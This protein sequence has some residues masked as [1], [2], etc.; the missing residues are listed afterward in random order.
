MSTTP[1]LLKLLTLATRAVEAELN[2]ELS[3]RLAAELRPAH[4][5]VFRY[6]DP[7]GSRVGELAAAAGMTQQSMGELV[8]RLERAGLVR[9][10]VDPQDRRAR[11]VVCTEAGLVALELAGERIAR[12]EDRIRAD[13]GEAGTVEL[14]RLLSRVVAVLDGAG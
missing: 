1:S 8:G 13:V 2:D 9:R 6:L 3:T 4:Y 11:Q 5:A 10:Q 14:R 12:I 7:A